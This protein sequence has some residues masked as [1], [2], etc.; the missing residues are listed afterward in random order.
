MH[1]SFWFFDIVARSAL[2]LCSLFDFFAGDLALSHQFINPLAMMLLRI[3]GL[4]RT[5]PHAMEGIRID[6]NGQVDMP[7]SGRHAEAG[8]DAV[9]RNH[10]GADAVIDMTGTKPE[11]ST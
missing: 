11:D 7:D 1:T 2:F 8:T 4:D 5:I 9:Q 10:P 6:T 3:A